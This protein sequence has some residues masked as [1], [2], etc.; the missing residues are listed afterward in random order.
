MFT[1]LTTSDVLF[2]TKKGE[3]VCFPLHELVLNE[4]LDDD[5]LDES[6]T[7]Y[8]VSLRDKEH[9]YEVDKDM[10]NW[11]LEAKGHKVEE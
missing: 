4:S 7:Y 2:S 5:S 10:F 11:L 8:A 3:R 6:M 9:R 1:Q